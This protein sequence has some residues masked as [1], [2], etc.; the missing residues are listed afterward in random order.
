MTHTKTPE[1]LTPAEALDRLADAKCQLASY[2]PPKA[3]DRFLHRVKTAVEFY[4]TLS[5]SNIAGELRAL[6]SPI[7]AIE[8]SYQ[9]MATKIAGLSPGARAVLEQFGAIPNASE[10]KDKRTRERAIETL[11][12]N[13]VQGAYIKKEKQQRR[14]TKKIVGSRSRGRPSNAREQVLV[15]LLAAAFADATGDSTKRSW[16]NEYHE[17]DGYSPFERLVEDILV[18]LDIDDQHSAKKLV[19]QHVEARDR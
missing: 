12:G 16:S 4:L 10:F 8:H 15:S 6:A 5:N 19:Q 17:H 1:R 2:V 13:L 7:D 9:D 11:H 3:A 18:T 14:Y